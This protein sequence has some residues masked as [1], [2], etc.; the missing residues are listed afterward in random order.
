M[1]QL[2]PQ[3]FRKDQQVMTSKKSAAKSPVAD[4]SQSRGYLFVAVFVGVIILGVAFVLLNNNQQAGNSGTAN[5][6][7]LA[8]VQ[9]FPILSRDHIQPGQAH[10]AYNSNPPTNGWH[11]PVWADWGIYNQEIPDEYMVHNLEHGGVWISYKDPNDSQTISQIQTLVS[12]DSDRMIVT[13][14]PA[15][16]TTIAVAAWG[17]L[18]KL[19]KFDADAIKAFVQRYRY[20]GP[21]NI[22]GNAGG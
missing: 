20:Q 13:L 12:N 9:T 2:P 22:P 6:A 7:S 1:V 21:E 14:R 11:Y 4:S 5:S 15:D 10:P 16:D 8:N 17:V 18:L 3:L 19:D